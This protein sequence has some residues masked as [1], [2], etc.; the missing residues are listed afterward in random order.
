MNLPPEPPDTQF[1]PTA[2]FSL[3]FRSQALRELHEYWRAK[4]NGRQLP[5][6]S[7]L[8]PVEI[9][10]LL[11]HVALVD[12]EHDPL[13]LRFRLIG[14]HITEA[15]G[16]DSTGKYFDDAYDEEIAA[17]MTELYKVS[18]NSKAPIRHYS[19]AIFAG[20]DYRHYEA[21]H[22]PLSDDGENVTM[23]LVGLQFFE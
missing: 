6:R 4:L 15:T 8:D 18:I 9:P 5:T 13:R 1:P 3:D 16:R 10:H 21:V 2:D 20:Q 12:V 7:D 17:G 22:L 11:K 14:T 19:R 23:V